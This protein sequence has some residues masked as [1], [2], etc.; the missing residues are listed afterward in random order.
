EID[1]RGATYAF[2]KIRVKRTFDVLAG[3]AGKMSDAD[4]IEV[5]VHEAVH[6]LDAPHWQSARDP[7]DRY[8]TEFR[9]YW[10]DGSYGQPDKTL[11]PVPAHGCKPAIVDPEMPAPGPK[12]PRARAIFKHLYEDYRYVKPAYDE[13]EDGFRDAV[14]QYVV[15][16]GINLLLSVRLERLRK[17]IEDYD[18]S[19]FFA[20]RVDVRGFIGDGPPPADGVLTAPERAQMRGNRAWRDHVEENVP[21]TGEQKLIK[22]DLGIAQ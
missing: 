8:K 17:L 10:M 5:L 22:R 11:S 1:T 21:K 12:S 2:K 3:A 19:D 13:N 14:D 18:E 9:A 7:I 6:A 4:V 15:P 16:D 20:F